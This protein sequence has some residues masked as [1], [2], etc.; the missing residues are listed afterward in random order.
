MPRGQH[1]GG[2][3]VGVISNYQERLS[4]LI[5]GDWVLGCFVWDASSDLKHLTCRFAFLPVVSFDP[6]TT[7]EVG[8]AG[9]SITV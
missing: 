3:G 9:I 1:T 6:P 2:L 7:H 8:R 5:V 4:E